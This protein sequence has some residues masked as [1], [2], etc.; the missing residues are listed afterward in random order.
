[1]NLLRGSFMRQAALL[2]ALMLWAL[3]AAAQPLSWQELCS[4]ATLRDLEPN[5]QAAM[6]SSCTTALNASRILR[7]PCNAGISSEH[8]TGRKSVILSTAR[9]F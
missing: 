5:C 7:Q 1:M 8:M 6:S 3:I 9:G 4:N 2:L